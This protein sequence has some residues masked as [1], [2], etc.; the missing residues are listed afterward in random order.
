MLRVFGLLM[1]FLIFLSIAFGLGILPLYVIFSIEIWIGAIN[2]LAFSFLTAIFIFYHS[3]KGK[4]FLCDYE[5]IKGDSI[6]IQKKEVAIENF[7]YF[8]L[9]KV[10]ENWF[11]KIHVSE[12]KKH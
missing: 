12:L 7:S 2:A 9:M 3:D 4:L 8:R 6:S 11:K 10:S 1:I 5:I